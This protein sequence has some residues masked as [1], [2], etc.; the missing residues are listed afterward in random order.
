MLKIFNK[1]M[2]KI[3][4][5]LSVFQTCRNIVLYFSYVLLH[6][7]SIF[8]EGKNPYKILKSLK[9]NLIF[10]IC[11]VHEHCTKILKNDNW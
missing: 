4:K 6:I 3:R 8:K 9:N 10:N 2:E 5:S 7:V 1:L 11:E